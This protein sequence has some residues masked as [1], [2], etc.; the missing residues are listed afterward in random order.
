MQKVQKRRTIFLARMVAQFLMLNGGSWSRIWMWGQQ[1][2]HYNDWNSIE[3]RP[4]EN[5]KRYS[6][7]MNWHDYWFTRTAL[8]VSVCRYMQKDA[9]HRMLHNQWTIW[10]N[11]KEV[12]QAQLSATNSRRVNS[13]FPRSEVRFGSII[14]YSRVEPC[15]FPSSCKMLIHFD[16]RI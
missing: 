5:F 15:R 6:Q 10:K 14:F 4:D 9:S 16:N 1:L 12:S 2:L 7:Q 13:Q 3:V 11:K 8:M